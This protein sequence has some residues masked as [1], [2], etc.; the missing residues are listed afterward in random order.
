MLFISDEEE[1]NVPDAEVTRPRFIKNKAHQSSGSSGSG[2]SSKEPSP[3][4]GM[5]ML[6]FTYLT[7]YHR[8]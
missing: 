3:I 6:D 5:H 7:T 8:Y 2:H 4:K 1:N